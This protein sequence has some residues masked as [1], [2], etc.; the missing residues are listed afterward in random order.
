MLLITKHCNPY[1]EEVSALATLVTFWF[2]VVL[3]QLLV[4]SQANIKWSQYIAR[5]CLL[6]K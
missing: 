6:S 3:H 4:S 2:M 1:A 5:H